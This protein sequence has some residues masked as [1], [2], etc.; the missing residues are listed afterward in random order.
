MAGIDLLLHNGIIYTMNEQNSK[1][2][3]VVVKDGKIQDL[4]LKEGYKKYENNAIEI[5][6]LKG[7]TVLPGFY[8]SHVHLMQTG[9]NLMSLD[10]NHIHCIDELLETL[11]DASKKIEKHEIIR[12]IG[13]D[14]MKTVEKRMPNR[15][16]LDRCCPNHPVWINRVEYHMSSVNTLLLSKLNL[17]FNLE[18]ILRDEK[19][20]PDGRL[21]GRANTYVR[22]YIFENTPGS[23]KK[24]AI[25]KAIDFAINK[26]VTTINALEGGSLYNDSSIQYILDNKNILPIDVKLFYQTTDV[27]KSIEEGLTCIG[28]DIFLDG[29]F[30]SRT[31]AL[32]EPYSDGPLVKGILYYTQDELNEFILKAH[33]NDLQISLHAI[34]ERAIDQAIYGYEYAQKQQPKHTRHRI[35]HFELATDEQIIK[36]RE[37]NLVVSM[38]PAYEYYWGG[39]G[40]MYEARIGDRY[41][42]TNRFKKIIQE[43]ICIAGGSDSDVTTMD[44]IL[45]IH[46]AVNHPVQ[47]NSIDGIDAV[48][49]FTVNSAYAVYED[50]IKGSI[51]KDKKGDFVILEED[52]FNC[53]D[54]TKIKDIRVFGTIKEGNI[55]LMK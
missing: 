8:D 40:N 9:L 6:D 39:K 30:G 33:E 7:R 53:S 3:W 52:I 20:L 36:A 46:A 29:S 12:G 24:E 51:E 27:M 35:E 41:K 48:K 1:C 19:G 16:E 26:G 43:G 32:K 25:Y 5:I 22:K 13:F 10:L 37:L 21:I 55:L 49:M 54:K 17:P 28:G 38:Q 45:G 4:G 23:S 47:E 31:A 34:G 2:N 50:S 18:G 42:R 44:P 15:R 11:N 14:E